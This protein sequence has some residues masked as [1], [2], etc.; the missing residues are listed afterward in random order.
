MLTN[1][2]LFAGM[3]ALFLSLKEVPMAEVV[4]FAL[5][6]CLSLFLSFSQMEFVVNPNYS[7]SSLIG[8]A[9]GLCLCLVVIG[10]LWSQ[11]YSSVDKMMPYRLIRYSTFISFPLMILGQGLWEIIYAKVYENGANPFYL[12]S[13]AELDTQTILEGQEE[14]QTQESVN[15]EL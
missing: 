5:Y 6:L 12:P 4:L 11:V 3:I 2:I 13:Q 15:V 14:E 8:N 9:L 7:A 10:M 1:S